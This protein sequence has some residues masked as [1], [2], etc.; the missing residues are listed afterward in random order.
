MTVGI[1]ILFGAYDLFIKLG[2]GKISPSLG[3]MLTQTTSTL[4]LVVI[5]LL[6]LRSSGVVKQ[7]IT[8]EG[9]LFVVL[10]GIL[11]A[12]ALVLLFS[13]LQNK[14]ITTATTLPVILIL[15]NVTLVT[16]ALIVLHENLTL[17]KILGLSMSLLGIYLISFK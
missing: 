6:Q 16:L 8:L 5:F 10:A 13:L 14:D 15:R 9:I 3:A 11:I 7:L 1:A 2:A 12:V 4:V 17:T